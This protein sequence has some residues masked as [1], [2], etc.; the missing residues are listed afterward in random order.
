[1]RDCCVSQ[2]SSLDLRVNHL[3][4][5]CHGVIHYLMH[6]I[7]DYRHLRGAK[8]TQEFLEN[9]SQLYLGDLFPPM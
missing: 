5:L 6:R 1:M 8:K 2:G 7:W 3:I 4:S 9:A